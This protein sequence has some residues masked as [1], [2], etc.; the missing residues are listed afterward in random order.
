MTERV[1]GSLQRRKQNAF[2]LKKIDL[3]E[4]EMNSENFMEISNLTLLVR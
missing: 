3:F 1:E 4:I 2:S